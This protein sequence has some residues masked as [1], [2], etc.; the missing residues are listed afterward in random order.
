V[1]HDSLP[2]LQ[3][4]KRHDDEDNMVICDWCQAGVHVYCHQPALTEIPDEQDEWFCHKCTPI[5]EKKNIAMAILQKHE[6][7]CA[8]ESLSKSQGEHKVQAM[9][10]LLAGVGL[11]GDTTGYT[12]AEEDMSDGELDKENQNVK[13]MNTLRKRG[14]SVVPASAELFLAKKEQNGKHPVADTMTVSAA[15]CTV[16]STSQGVL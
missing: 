3:E 16:A 5:V 12:P 10:D 14:E 15:A 13:E 8:S 4:C 9:A 7:A 6:K 1:P 11:E 2:L